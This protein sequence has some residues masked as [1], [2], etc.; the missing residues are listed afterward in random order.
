MEKMNSVV[1]GGARKASV[2]KSTFLKTWSTPQKA[3]KESQSNDIHF[4]LFC[5]LIQYYE[6]TMLAILDYY[7]HPP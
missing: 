4:D 6:A 3:A 1:A 7:S 5:V 2:L